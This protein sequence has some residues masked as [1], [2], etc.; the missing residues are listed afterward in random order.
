MNVVLF[1]KE[2]C[3]VSLFLANVV[4]G[5]HYMSTFKSLIF[6]L[7]GI[8]S[9]R[10]LRWYWLSD[11]WVNNDFARTYHNNIMKYNKFALQNN[12]RAHI[13]FKMNGF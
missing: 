13:S 8:T 6:S 5:G 7:N 10:F 11:S 1:K 4:L 2:N 9:I 3:H 12:P